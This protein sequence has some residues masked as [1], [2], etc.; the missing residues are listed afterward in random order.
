MVLMLLMSA[1]TTSRA[2]DVHGNARVFRGRTNTQNGVENDQDFLNQFYN[3]NLTQNI[4]PW[5]G[6]ELGFLYTDFDTETFNQSFYRNSRTPSL[7]VFYNRPNIS[8]FLQY[9]NR[10]NRSS[11]AVQNL[12]VESFLA[13]FNWK[14]YRGPEYGLQLRQDTNQAVDVATFGRDIRS[15]IADASVLYEQRTWSVAYRLEF[16]KL[17]NRETGLELTQQRNEFRGLFTDRYWDD[18]IDITAGARLSFADQEQTIP[19]GSTLGEPVPIQVGL[20]LLDSTPDLDA[21]D[22][23]PDLADGDVITPARTG[24]LPGDPTIQ[25]GGANTDRNLGMDLGFI[26]TISRI[27]VFVDAVSGPNILWAVYKS[28]DNLNWTEV[29][30]ATAVFDQPFLRYDIRFPE[31]TNRFFKVVN[32][33]ANSQANVAVTELSA[34]L[35]LQVTTGESQKRDAD[36]YRLNFGFS[37]A[38]TERVTAYFNL[39]YNENRSALGGL[40][41][42]RT[43][44]YA[45]DTRMLIKT[46]RFSMLN[47]RYRF[48]DFEQS[49]PPQVFNTENNYSASYTW[50]PPRN[51]ATEVIASRRI[52]TDRG[53]L[54]RA[55]NLMRTEVTADLLPSVRA[56]GFL[57]YN[58]TTDPLS[59]FDSTSYRLGAGLEGRVSNSATVSGTISDQRFDYSGVVDLTQRVWLEMGG[60]WQVNPF[61]TLTGRVGV[62]DDH[63]SQGVE[64]NVSQ[65]YTLNWTPGLRLVTGI[66]YQDND[67][68]RGS[69]VKAAGANLSYR[70]NP[71]FTIFGNASRTSTTTGP[72]DQRQVVNLLAGLSFNF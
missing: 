15:R 42:R 63:R 50:T 6:F 33:T 58:D 40:V 1:A 32:I 38:P 8:A 60:T 30:G 52:E 26:R 12:D 39:Y 48:T 69:R 61:V 17:D 24:N 28:S 13:T 59:G 67:D 47:L 57:S 36:I 62:K 35:D 34:I 23:A 4:G 65:R 19:V 11:N 71:R 53:T 2:V 9:N 44:D 72:T 21:L 68:D 5:L 18:R 51:V 14:P 27:Q 55:T 16:L 3:L 41:G 45:Y 22:P 46:S 29:V 56:L 10:M 31:T 66:Y 43:V 64:R 70:I 20:Y 7:R 49:S 54:L 37:I 25:I